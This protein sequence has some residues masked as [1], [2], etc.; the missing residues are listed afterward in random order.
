M[1]V[2]DV[3]VENRHLAIDAFEGPES[4][5]PL[6]LQSADRIDALIAT[7]I[8]TASLNAAGL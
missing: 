3:S 1:K 5:I 2:V 4:E 8:L 6:L 7:K